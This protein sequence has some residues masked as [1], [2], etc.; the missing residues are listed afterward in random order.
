MK[1][2]KLLYK[3]MAVYLFAALMGFLAVTIICRRISY[4]RV[5]NSYS[6]R[7]YSSIA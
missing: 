7:L 3:H 5:F 2:N 6:E 4:N 1:V